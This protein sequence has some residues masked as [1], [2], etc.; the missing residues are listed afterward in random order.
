MTG[1]SARH[2]PWAPALIAL[3]EAILLLA[4]MVGVGYDLWHLHVAGYLP[5]PFIWDP[6]D[7][8]MDWFNPAYW[9]HQPGVYSVWGSI[10]PPISFVLLKALSI[11][12][13][14]SSSPFLGRDCDTVGIVSI[15]AIYFAAMAVTWVSFRRHHPLHRAV[16]RTLAVALGY[17]ALF[18]LERGNLLIATYIGFVLAF[19]SVLRSRWGRAF[20]AAVTINFKPYLL[21]STLAWAVLRQWRLLERAALATV[22]VYLATWAIVG[23]GSLGEIVA[24]MTNWV[25]FTGG[26]AVTEVYYA[27]SYN[28][29]FDLVKHGFPIANIM[30]SRTY[31]IF[32][33]VVTMAMRI[34]QLTGVGAMVAGWLQPRAISEH[35]LVALLVLLSLTQQSPGGYASL[36]I[37]YIVFLEPWRGVGPIIATIITYLV[38]LP[39]DWV[40]AYLP[41][42]QTFAWL[43]GRGVT[44]QFGIALGQFIRPFGLLVILFAL[45]LDTIAAVARNH[46]RWRPSLGLG[47]GSGLPA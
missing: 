4:I 45:S 3:P 39:V 17:P 33:L 23:S 42:P 46:H 2:L 44:A 38:S 5:Q 7:T 37:V 30:P 9:A 11:P 32:H 31:D 21:F 35:R 24:N 47:L 29:L 28:G 6:S 27:T 12:G 19:G 13:C 18:A 36:F 41:E 1:K 26:D 10:Y 14:Y 16:I 22:A 15:L 20:A 43:T 8:F 40:F 25:A 34:V